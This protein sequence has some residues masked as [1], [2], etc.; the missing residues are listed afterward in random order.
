MPCWWRHADRPRGRS[1]EGRGAGLRRARW[2]ISLIF[3]INGFVVAS[4]VPHIPEVKERL[5]LGE[6][7]L[8]IALLAMAVGSVLALPFA[9][10][11]AGRFGS[12]MA[13][14]TAG[15]LLCLLLPALM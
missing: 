5:A 15:L 4:W 13:T 7:Q 8:G 10:W 6:F 12:D 14:R 3:L 9:G 2:S 11:L 1:R